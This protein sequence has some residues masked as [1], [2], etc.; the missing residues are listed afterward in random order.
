MKKSPQNEPHTSKLG[1]SVVLKHFR[2]NSMKTSLSSQKGD[3]LRKKHW[4]N[5]KVCFSQQVW[6]GANPVD[7][8]G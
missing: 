4:N 1:F 3:Y 2:V 7:N 8:L 5:Q 6:K